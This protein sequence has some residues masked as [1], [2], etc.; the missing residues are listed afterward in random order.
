MA[1]LTEEE[2]ATFSDMIQWGTHTLEC[3]E[4]AGRAVAE[5]RRRRAADLS[6]GDRAGLRA[7]LEDVGEFW[8]GR[9]DAAGVAMKRGVQVLRRLLGDTP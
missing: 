3:S 8:A 9:E 6:G 5:L 7:I 4:R 1:D 2:L